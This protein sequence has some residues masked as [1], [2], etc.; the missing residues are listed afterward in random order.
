MLAP[1]TPIIDL[2]AAH[3]FY[4]PDGGFYDNFFFLLSIVMENF[5]VLRQE[6]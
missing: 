6:A 1:L 3:W 4:T 2:Y 5:L